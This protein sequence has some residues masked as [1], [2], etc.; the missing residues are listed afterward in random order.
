MKV[1]QV[2]SR[3]HAHAWARIS[4][5]H[6]RG[7]VTTGPAGGVRGGGNAQA[8][9]D[10]QRTAGES[11]Q[12]GAHVGGTRAEHGWDVEPTR[13][14]Q[15]GTRATARLTEAQGGARARQAAPAR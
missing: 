8:V 13:A 6:G 1:L 3:Q 14:G 5:V 15:V 11:A 2:G 7:E 10:P 9:A 12:A 4:G